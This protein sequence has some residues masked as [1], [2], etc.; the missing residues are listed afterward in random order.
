MNTAIANPPEY[1]NEE[2]H[3]QTLLGYV[4][5]VL[6]PTYEKI[7]VAEI[8]TVKSSMGIILPPLNAH[9][10]VELRR[11]LVLAVGCGERIDGTTE[12]RPHIVKPGDVVVY[13]WSASVETIIDTPT[14][15]E[16]LRFLTVDGLYG[17][18]RTAEV[19]G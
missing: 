6:E 5:K 14:G 8:E 2:D 10:K 11:G 17:I 18:E 7:L 3:A 4:P 1:R 12:I 9:S 19:S 13:A 16:K 15:R